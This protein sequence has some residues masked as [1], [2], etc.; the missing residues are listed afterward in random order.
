MYLLVGI[1]GR[2]LLPS[3]VACWRSA[4]SRDILLKTFPPKL[5]SA[6][7]QKGQING[8]LSVVFKGN[9]FGVNFAYGLSRE[10]APFVQT[11]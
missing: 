11:C 10:M 7:A 3:A 2:T 8:A 4:G 9:G 1:S 5:G 6:S